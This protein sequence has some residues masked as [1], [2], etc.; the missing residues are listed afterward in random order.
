VKIKSFNM[1]NWA[2]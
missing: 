1:N 2:E